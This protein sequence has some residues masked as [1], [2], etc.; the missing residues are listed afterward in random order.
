MYVDPKSDTYRH[1]QDGRHVVCSI[2]A[3]NTPNPFP[4]TGADIQGLDENDI[5][6]MGTTLLVTNGANAYI[7][8]ENGV[9][10]PVG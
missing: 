10:Q 9:F 2:T 7:M 8:D 3:T 6:D 5:L 1:K 4:T